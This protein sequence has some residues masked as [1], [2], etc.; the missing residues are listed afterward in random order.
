MADNQEPQ[1]RCKEKIGN[2][3][4]R[5]YKHCTGE[6][7]MSPTQIGAAKLY[8]GKTLPD[9]ASVALTNDGDN[10]FQVQV[11]MNVIG[12]PGNT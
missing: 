4:N 5:L 12:K 1:W 7:K 8:L 11:T 6:I 10:K 9:L 3:M 2:I